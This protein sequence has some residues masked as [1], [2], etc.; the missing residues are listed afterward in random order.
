LSLAGQGIVSAASFKDLDNISGMDKIVD[1]QQS[2]VIDGISDDEFAPHQPITQAESIQLFVKALGLNLDL[3]RF[4]KEP[5]A[6]DYFA[7][8]DDS[9]WYANSLITAAANGLDLPK[10]LKPDQKLTREAFI[11]QLVHAIEVSGK[12]PM[13]KPV[14]VEF[15]DQDEVTVGY[16][17]SIQRALNYGI[18]KLDPD[19]KVKPKVEMT[20]AEAAI[21]ISNALDYLKAH[22]APVASSETLTMEQG[23][24]LI[25][26]ANGSDADLQIKIDPNA[27]L[28]RESFTYLLIHTLQTSGKLPMLNVVPVE[29]KDQEQ[30]EMTNSGAIQTAIA[31]KIVELDAYGNFHPKDVI[32]RAE[33]T[34]MVNNVAKVLSRLSNPQ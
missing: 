34:T 25:K 30:I 17:G 20:R 23:V 10:D 2:G 18:L 3:I 31:L 26:E 19:G 27:S 11:H 29:V 8:A 6:T 28:T 22:S 32:T 12:L 14:V 33:A 4:F 7:N 1:L 15:N 9:A 24:Q 5:K 13:L 16:S 21:A